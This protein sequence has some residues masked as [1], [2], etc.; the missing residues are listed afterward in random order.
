MGERE[1]GMLVGGLGIIVLTVFVMLW[2][3]LRAQRRL[4]AEVV[5]ESRE[6]REE[7]GRLMEVMRGE[8]GSGGSVCL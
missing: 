5:R 1:V 2:W 6:V 7:L 3:D 8:G 4:V